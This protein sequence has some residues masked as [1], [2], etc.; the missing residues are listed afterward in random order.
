MFASGEFF[1][2]AGES[3]S[4]TTSPLSTD[5]SEAGT[6]T[7][8][9]RPRTRA[10]TRTSHGAGA[11]AQSP[12]EASSPWPPPRVQLLQPLDELGVVGACRR[13]RRKGR[14][15]RTPAERETERDD[16][17]VSKNARERERV[18]NVNREYENLR[19]ALGAPPNAKGRVKKVAT[20]NHAINYIK[21][22]MSE[23]EQ[24]SRQADE[25]PQVHPGPSS[26]N[27]SGPS[28]DTAVE[29]ALE[30]DAHQEVR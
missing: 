24:L 10:R 28:T 6:P 30:T 20:L 2:S 26:S 11:P 7:V 15:N 16:R 23:L 13:G 5:G 17:R 29:P 25:S 18:E 4:S 21:A 27:G 14:R 1:N 9:L 8:R 22:L 3:D 19:A 12:S